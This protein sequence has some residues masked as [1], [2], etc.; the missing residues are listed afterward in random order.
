MVDAHQRG[1]DGIRE[2]WWQI[3]PVKRRDRPP[4]PQSYWPNASVSA[5]RSI[6]WR[7]NQRRSFGVTAGARKID[8][9]HWQEERTPSVHQSAAHTD[10]I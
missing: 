3:R 2:Y 8:L 6:G 5:T 7:L 9:W 4:K 1:P 10:A